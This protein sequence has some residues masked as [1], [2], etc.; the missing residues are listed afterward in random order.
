MP[1]EHGWTATEEEFQR[2]LNRAKEAL[3]EY[4]DKV[5]MHDEG[6]VRY[7][8]HQLGSRIKGRPIESLCHSRRTLSVQYVLRHPCISHWPSAVY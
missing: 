4:E 6:L 7:A 8:F 1:L 5:I 2:H 3:E